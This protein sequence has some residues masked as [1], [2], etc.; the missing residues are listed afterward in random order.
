MFA[1]SSNAA[2]Q[3]KQ[4]DVS[5]IWGVRQYNGIIVT[6]DLKQYGDNFTGYASFQ[7]KKRKE[8]GKVTGGHID[9][10]AKTGWKIPTSNI[11]WEVAWDYG[12][13]GIY[14]GHIDAKGA[15]DGHAWI[16]EDYN[17]EKRQTDWWSLRNR[18]CKVG[19]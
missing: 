17:N 16:K 13:T 5:G 10:L 19:Y 6:L 7:G 15:L 2:A 1:L 9:V 18:T 14:R 12:E 11:V 4:W 8:T 3:C